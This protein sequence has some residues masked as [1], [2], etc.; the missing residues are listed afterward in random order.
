MNTLNEMLARAR[1]VA[2]LTGAGISTGA[3][4]PTYRGNGGLYTDLAMPPLHASHATPEK[5]HIIWNH[6]AMLIAADISPTAAHISISSYAR[7]RNVTVIT[8]NIDGLHTRSAHEENSGERVIELHG[9]ITTVTCLGCTTGWQRNE[10]ITEPDS[11]VPFCPDCGHPTRPDVTLFGEQL[12]P[13]AFD[14][15]GL[16]VRRADVLL[17]VGTS[18]EVSPANMLVS[19]TNV[20]TPVVHVNPEAPAW[21]FNYF[22]HISG[23]ADNILPALLHADM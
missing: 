4:L 8:Q 9:T 20:G 1:R 18:L 7:D 10:C 11:H 23:T 14:D 12:P 13:G 16:A 3:G 15:A 21:Q 6:L 22:I 19:Y 17:V 5:V 2:V